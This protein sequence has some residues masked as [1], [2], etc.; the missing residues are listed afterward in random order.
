M[1]HSFSNHHSHNPLPPT[2]N[3]WKEGLQTVALSL[4][5][6]FGIRTYV[7]EA[8]FVPTGSM[9]PTIEIDD[10]F[11][12]DKLTTR[13]QDPKRGEIL[14]FS[15]PKALLE[16]NF[17]DALIKRVIGLPGD[18]VEIKDGTVWVNGQVLNEP[19]TKE[20]AKYT[21]SPVTVPDH[22]YLMLGDNRNNSNDSH[23]WG[24][25]P[26]ENIIGRATFRFY[27]PNRVGGV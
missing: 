17:K 14:V 22:Q 25:V 20:S 5:L 2:E 26:R 7:A 1:R 23:I 21:M 18:R 24:F 11:I 19:Y 15:P 9:Q 4:F 10:R 6:A 3:R 8:R 13:W 16:Q 12:I 27:P